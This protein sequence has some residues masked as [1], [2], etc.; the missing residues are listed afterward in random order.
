M[1]FTALKLPSPLHV[2]L[3]RTRARFHGTTA[4]AVASVCLH[5]IYWASC[6][7]SVA[8]LSVVQDACCILSVVRV[9]CCML[10]QRCMLQAEAT[11][12]KI[13]C[14]NSDRCML[15]CCPLHPILLFVASEIWNLVFS[16]CCSADGCTLNFRYALSFLQV[17][18][19]P[20]ACCNPV[21]CMLQW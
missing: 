13:A 4:V 15:Q 14:C 7:V 1:H 5:D 3:R 8:M 9:A 21:C 12:C 20:V 16:A 10:K 2:A 6:T 18:M 17:A 11:C 19:P